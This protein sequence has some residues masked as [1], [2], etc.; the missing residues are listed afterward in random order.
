MNNVY[1][2][3]V[4][5]TH[6]IKGE[7]RILSDFLYKEKAFLVGSKIIIDHMEYKIL[8]YRK[9]KEFDMITLEG[10]SNINDVLFLKGK[11]VYKEK[12]ELNLSEEEILDSDLIQF[13]VIDK[14]KNC[15]IIKEIFYASPTNKI[16]RVE[17]TCEVLIPLNSPMIKRIDPKRKE[18]EVD[19][20]KGMI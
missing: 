20:I 11:K 2:G 17:F 10:Y 5:N 15:G 14:N 16:I 19:L 6:G 8:S 13:K 12:T 7:I 1:I 18:I 4:V 3:R 9:H